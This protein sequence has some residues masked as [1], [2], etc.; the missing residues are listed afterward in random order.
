MP[1]QTGGVSAGTFELME[2]EGADHI[3]IKILG[4]GV[5]KFVSNRYHSN[6]REAKAP[7][8]LGRN[9]ALV[10]GVPACFC[11]TRWYDNIKTPGS[12]QSDGKSFK[13]LCAGGILILTEK[14]Q[15][16]GR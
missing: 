3:I 1:G 4:K 12:K 15:K 6:I 10:G 2:L 8:G 7:G 9:E 5:V 16:N 14:F 11:V 13:F